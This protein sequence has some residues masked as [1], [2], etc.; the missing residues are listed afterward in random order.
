MLANRYIQLPEIAGWEQHVCTGW[1]GVDDDQR[2]LC[3]V[4][5][6]VDHLKEQGISR[7]ILAVIELE[8]WVEMRTDL[9]QPDLGRGRVKG[10]R[11]N[12]LI[13]QWR[14]RP[15]GEVSH[16]LLRMSGAPVA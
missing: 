13:V 5:E 4:I 6:A 11:N 1:R 8:S 9:R 3:T 15:E 14:N 12:K 7:G 2:M 16:H 10:V